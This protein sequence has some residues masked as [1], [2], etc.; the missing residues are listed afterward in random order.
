MNWYRLSSHVKSIVSSSDYIGFHERLH[1]GVKDEKLLDKMIHDLK[2]A[3][4]YIVENSYLQLHPE[5][6]RFCSQCNPD[7]DTQ[8][9]IMAW[10]D[11]TSKVQDDQKQELEATLQQNKKGFWKCD[12]CGKVDG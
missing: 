11:K 10:F 3:I 6:G 7:K 1:K 5:M 2:P 9:S 4:D 8:Q 12:S